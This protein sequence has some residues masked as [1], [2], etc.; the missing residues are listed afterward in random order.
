MK[1]KRILLLT[2]A[3]LL[4]AFAAF[5]FLLPAISY[6]PPRTHGITVLVSILPAR[7]AV[8]KYVSQHNTLVGSGS[9]ITLTT[10]LNK[11]SLNSAVVTPD[12]IIFGYNRHYGI[13]ILLEPSIVQGKLQWRCVAMPVEA[14]PVMCR[15]GSPPLTTQS[16]GPP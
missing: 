6:D 16:R 11:Y 10:S 7:N 12:G 13:A 15:P 1:L 8:A 5:A 14:S 9:G 3:A 4:V 2:A